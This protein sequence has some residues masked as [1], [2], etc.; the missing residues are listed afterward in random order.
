MSGGVDSSTAACILKKQGLDV[1]G[2]FMYLCK[3]ALRASDSPGRC[4]SLDDARDAKAVAN[5]LGVKLHFLDLTAEFENII[6]YFT[7]EYTRG[8]TPNPCA[9]C[10]RDVK[11][12]ALMEKARELGC[13]TLATGHHARIIVKNG[14]HFIARAE[15]KKKDQSYFLFALSEE[16]ISKSV[17]PCGDMTKSEVRKIAA[18]AK[19]PVAEK[20]ESME[21][22][23]AD[24]K[25][26]GEFIAERAPE[27]VKP[28]PF[29]DMDGKVVGEH[30]GIQYYTIGQR[31]GVR[32]AFGEPRYVVKIDAPKNAVV[33]GT[34]KDLETDVVRANGN[35]RFPD[36]P[37]TEFH[38]S[39]KIRYN[40]PAFPCTIRI[41]EPGI[42]EARFDSPV[43]AVTPGQ[44]LV[45]YD[46]DLVLGG[47]WIE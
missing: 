44:A 14:R 26:P 27:S 42:I 35:L 34:E 33:I 9:V 24:V 36:E 31:R 46:G 20:R 21:V 17:F 7:A 25:S 8:R 38:A 5:A 6:N 39:A 18:G 41:P 1:E 11:F 2:A 29:L 23:F 37:Q 3:N 15:D 22:C 32:I 10:N 47:G 4:C 19:L 40:S 16:Q 13:D 28:G 12:G 30:R 45:V 43:R